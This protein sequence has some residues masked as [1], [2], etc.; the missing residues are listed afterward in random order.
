MKRRNR[1]LIA[2][3]SPLIVSILLGIGGWIY[4]DVVGKD[5]S[6]RVNYH[7]RLSIRLASVPS[8]TRFTPRS[9]SHYPN[10]GLIRIAIFM[11]EEL[12][13]WVTYSLLIYA[14][15]SWRDRRKRMDS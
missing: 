8:L 5:V 14:V 9:D 15:L 10:A 4:V 11:T 3:A 1:L 12:C 2:I 13:V 6:E 7:P